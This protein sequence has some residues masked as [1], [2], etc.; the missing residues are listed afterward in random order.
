MKY[1]LFSKYGVEIEYMIVDQETLQVL[2]ISDHILRTDTDNVTDEVSRPSGLN[3]SNE[4]AAHVIEVRPLVPVDSLATLADRFAQEVRSINERLLPHSACL[5]PTGA[6]PFMDPVHETTLWQHQWHEVYEHYDALF[7]CHRHGWANLQ[8]THLN[9]SFANDAEFAQ[10]HAAIRLVLPLIPA[11]AAS[12]PI[13]EGKC[14]GIADMRLEVYRTNQSRYPLITGSVIPEAAWTETE[15]TQKILQPLY[16]QIA[17]VD[18]DKILSTPALNS[19]GARVNFEEGRIEIRLIDSQECPAADIAICQ[20]ITACIQM[21]VSGTI[22]D[23][24]QQQKFTHIE[25]SQILQE[26][27]MN[28]ESAI[29]SDSNYLKTLGYAQDSVSAQKLLEHLL[30][31]VRTQTEELPWMEIIRYILKNG[32]LSS[33]ISRSISTAITQEKIISVYKKLALSLATN[34][35]FAA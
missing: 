16:A 20:F 19:R 13:L 11:L 24:A 12:T 30:Q 18:P 17:P 33:R 2:P 32:T 23:L 15:Y 26:C 21:L 29:I 28:A 3:W 31:M 27:I 14:T 1:S 7:D 34:Q 10:L 25:L 9:L 8:S 5:L 35:L 4:L 22:S 6:H